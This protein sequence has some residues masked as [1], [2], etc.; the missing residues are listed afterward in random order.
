MISLLNTKILV[1]Q[2]S[3]I[4]LIISVGFKFYHNKYKW[5]SEND[6]SIKVFATMFD[7]V[8]SIPR[9]HSVKRSDFLQVAL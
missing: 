1:F 5:A 6:Q 3:Q 8:N 9:T 4:F 7:D 2:T